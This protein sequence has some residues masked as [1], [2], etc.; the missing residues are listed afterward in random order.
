MRQLRLTS[1]PL[2]WQLTSNFSRWPKVPTT[3]ADL[4]ELHGLFRGW[5]YDVGG[6][7]LSENSRARY[8]DVQE[9]TDVCLDA[10]MQAGSPVPD[11]VYD[12]L[13]QACSALR[14]A[15]TEDLESRRQRS[16]IHR[17]RLA[18]THR[19]QKQKAAARLAEAKQ[20]AR[21]A[22]RPGRLPET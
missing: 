2:L 15:L 10:G 12:E 21:K 1:Y 20:R 19:R 22:T 18:A 9:L 3:Y 8:G 17:L 7:H 11:N 14:T 16:V 4:G 13:L 6:L 5:Y